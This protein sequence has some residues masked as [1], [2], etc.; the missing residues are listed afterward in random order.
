MRF[1]ILLILL[2]AAGCGTHPVSQ[3]PEQK[4]QQ[5]RNFFAAALEPEPGP[6][7]PAVPFKEACLKH[8]EALYFIINNP[9]LLLNSGIPQEILDTVPK[10]FEPL[11]GQSLERIAKELLTLQDSFFTDNQTKIEEAV[12]SFKFTL[13]QLSSIK[14]PKL[15]TAWTKFFQNILNNYFPSLILEDKKRI[16][17]FMIKHLKAENTETQNLLNWVYASGP[18]FHK[19]L[20]LMADY[21]EP[22]ND[23]RL[24]ELHKGLKEVK[25]GLPH[26]HSYYIERYLKELRELPENAVDLEIDVK[27]DSLGTASVGEAFLAKNKATGQRIVIKF[28]RPGIKE[29]AD[30]EREF[31]LSQATQGALRESFKEIADQIREELDY[32]IELKKIKNPEGTDGTKAYTGDSFKISVVEPLDDFPNGKHYFAMK[33][34]DGKTFKDLGATKL[35][36][37]TKSIL[38][39]KVARKFVHQALAATEH[40]FFHGDLHDGNIMVTFAPNHN[41]S[42]DPS[43]EQV[44]AAIDQGL[45]KVVLIDFGNAH[46]LSQEQRLR[47]KNIFLATSSISDS[48]DAFLY[49]MLPDGHKNLVVIRDELEKTVFN[50]ENRFKLPHHKIGEAMDVLLKHDAAI[51]GF[52]MAFKRSLAMLCNIYDSLKEGKPESL[53]PVLQSAYTHN[54]RDTILNDNTPAGIQ[55]FNDIIGSWAIGNVGRTEFEFFFIPWSKNFVTYRELSE[56]QKKSTSCWK[57]D[58]YYEPIRYCSGSA[59]YYA[60]KALKNSPLGFIITGTDMATKFVL[61]RVIRPVISTAIPVWQFVTKSLSNIPQGLLAGK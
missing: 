43:E 39:E 60:K 32:K 23:A 55:N 51:P 28:M 13:D 10:D 25:S 7:K 42:D 27:K 18:Y 44:K 36:R 53:D 58:N 1:I 49:A 5:I 41:L 46:I 57:G 37:L 50:H 26:I 34:V 3:T 2:I 9:D 19:Y 4:T 11:K 21:L 40:A 6:T 52:L 31:F 35:E 16:L 38:W 54:L 59:I 48:L 61:G 33:L 24:K 30:R 29:I 15:G 56:E 20:Q 17:A 8:L 22:G 47:L 45:I 14:V 12:M